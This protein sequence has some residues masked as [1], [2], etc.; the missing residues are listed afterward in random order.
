MSGCAF[1]SAFGRKN[2]MLWNLCSRR[3]TRPIHLH[4][5]TTL[6][7]ERTRT[8]AVENISS[9][10]LQR[11]LESS[12]ERVFDAWVNPETVKKWLFTTPTSES[13]TTQ[14]DVRVDGQ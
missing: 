3:K 6:L 8:M 9:L 5:T 11:R 2:S 12:P 14:I 10:R 1:M 4:Q 7:L 13:N